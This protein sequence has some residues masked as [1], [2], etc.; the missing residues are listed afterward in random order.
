MS[1]TTKKSLWL[2]ILPS[3]LLA[4]LVVFFFLSGWRLF[5]VKTPSMGQTAPVGSLVVVH[6][7]TS[8]KK[9]DIIAFSQND[10][11]YIHRI[12]GTD[13]KKNGAFITK[14]DLNGTVDPWRTDSNTIIG[15]AEN[16]TRHLGWLLLA[17]PW[18]VLGFIIV[19]LLSIAPKVTLPW[20]WPIRIMGSAIVVALVSIWLHPWINFGLLGYVPNDYA[21]VDMHIVNT[22]IFNI[23]AEGT[24]L[25]PGEDAT[26][27]IP[28]SDSAG[29]F[30]LLPRPALGFWGV[31]WMILFAL[32]PLFAALLLLPKQKESDKEKKKKSKDQLL[33]ADRHDVL[34]ITLIVVIVVT[35]LSLQLS[36]LAAFVAS[37]NN[38]ANNLKTRQ[39]FFCREV[40]ISGKPKPYLSYA[41]GTT[42]ITAQDISGNGRNGTFSSA[43]PVQNGDIG[44]LRD[45]P[46]SSAF[47][48]RCLTHESWVTGPSVFS[49]AVWFKT[50][51][52]TTNNSGKLVGFGNNAGISDSSYDRHIYIDKDGRVVFGV[53][54][55]TVRLVSSPVGKNYADNNW[56]HVVLTM[57][58]TGTFLYLDGEQAGSDPTLTQA[59]SYGGYWKFGCGRLV[60]WRNADG[61]SAAT[62]SYFRGSLQYGS[63]YHDV[64]LSP[65]VIRDQYLAGA[66]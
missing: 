28:Y 52:R 4:G 23:N 47:E 16:I 20:R 3:L 45:T 53:Y 42:G 21:G 35:L 18:L 22:G 11:V 9:G 1:N 61:T 17:L 38:S 34:I 6:S 60:G 49:I 26:I 14:G 43:A 58:P 25:S 62:P 29:R 33:F 46:R 64:V 10:R 2:W 19:Y 41:M 63:I 32:L 12:T 36:A 8:Y 57:G 5:V 15:R 13:Q 54:P 59:Q 48:N 55:G 31:I 51:Y 30:V 27:N 44:C 24:I 56:H 39:F 50:P 40:A 7:Q 66:Q 65:E 37:I